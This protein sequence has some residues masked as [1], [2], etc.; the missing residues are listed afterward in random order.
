MIPLFHYTVPG[1]TLVSGYG[2]FI[3]ITTSLSFLKPRLSCIALR[4]RIVAYITIHSILVM[5]ADQPYG[6]CPLKAFDLPRR[7]AR[8]LPDRATEQQETTLY[9]H[10]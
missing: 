1:R 9:S 4:C 5:F 8:E 6:I 3:D 2:T 10:H 7:E